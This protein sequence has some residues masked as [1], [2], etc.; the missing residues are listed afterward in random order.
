[1]N[2]ILPIEKCK[3]ALKRAEK[4]KESLDLRYNIQEA[5]KLKGK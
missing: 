2:K 1:M 5:N 4:L 3:K